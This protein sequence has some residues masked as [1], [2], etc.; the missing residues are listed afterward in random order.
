M[1]KNSVYLN[2]TSRNLS[3][4]EVDKL[5]KWYSYYHKLYTCY[6]WK[7]KKL[8]KIKMG[9]NM[10]SK[11]L[12]VSG[13]IV[14]GVTLNPIILGCMSGPGTLIQG[15]LSNSNIITKTTICR[16]TYTTYQVLTQLKSYL[17]GIEYDEVV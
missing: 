3:E 2:H 17:R 16:F 8:K 5:I 15:Y 9:L 13:T 7:Y 10:T 12:T 4:E 1:K 11:G 6:K 14:G